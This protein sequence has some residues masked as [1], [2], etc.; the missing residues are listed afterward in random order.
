MQE[1]VKGQYKKTNYLF[2]NRTTASYTKNP[3][4][5]NI[6]TLLPPPNTPKYLDNVLVFV[7]VCIYFPMCVQV[8]ICF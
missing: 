8:C 7:Y 3:F 5:K 2:K 6:A 1:I 4:L